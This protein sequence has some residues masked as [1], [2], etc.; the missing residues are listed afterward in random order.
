[1]D[2]VITKPFLRFHFS[3]TFSSIDPQKSLKAAHSDTAVRPSFCNGSDVVSP[4]SSTQKTPASW[5]PIP[6]S[7]GLRPTCVADHV[8]SFLAFLAVRPFLQPIS[9]HSIHHSLPFCDVFL[10]TWSPPC[11]FQGVV[12]FGNCG[13]R[14]SYFEIA[15]EAFT[16][17]VFGRPR[18]NDKWFRFVV[19][20]NHVNLTMF[21]RK[22]KPFTREFLKGPCHY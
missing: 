15:C 11:H 8:A 3:L 20:K 22:T 10:M 9:T 16:P 4:P 21:K 12:V 5:P 17:F 1:M 13:K 7:R 14:F 2:L 6:D 19:P 18:L